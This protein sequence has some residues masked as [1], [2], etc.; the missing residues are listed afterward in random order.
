MKSGFQI[1]ILLEQ[2][3]VQNIYSNLI[4][5]FVYD[6]YTYV[7][8]EVSDAQQHK[9]LIPKATGFFL[10]LSPNILFILCY[11]M[12]P[13]DAP[14]LQKDTVLPDLKGNLVIAIL[15][16]WAHLLKETSTKPIYLCHFS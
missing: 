5:F 2:T 4:S 6:V 1:T 7:F 8:Q 11:P 9:R 3:A 14:A 16:I 10:F 13:V 12:Q 15:K